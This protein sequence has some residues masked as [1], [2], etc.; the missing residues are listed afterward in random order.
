MAAGPHRHPAGAHAVRQLARGDRAG[1]GS[2]ILRHASRGVSSHCSSRWVSWPHVEAARAGAVY[3]PDRP[4]MAHQVER[5]SPAV[6]ARRVGPV[7]TGSHDNRE[8]RIALWDAV[9]GSSSSWSSSRCRAAVVDRHRAFIAAGCSSDRALVTGAACWLVAVLALYGVLAW[10]LDTP[11]FPRYV[12]MLI[13]DPGHSSG[14][15]VRGAAGPGVEPAPMT[16]T[17]VPRDPRPTVS[18][19]DAVLARRWRSSACRVILAVVQ[20]V[21]FH[22]RNRSNGALVPRAGAGVPAS[23]AEEL[24]PQPADAARDQHARRGACGAPPRWKSADGTRWPTRRLHRGVSVGTRGSGPRS[25]ARRRGSGLTR[26]VDSS[27]I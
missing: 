21:S 16:A 24:R 22:V 10:L 8:V 27:R 12:L 3:R 14:A 15:A 1:P 19:A 7:S 25:L 4:R 6:V 17:R 11:F 9:P 20:A 5:V 18:A 2:T 26:D 23:R 13:R